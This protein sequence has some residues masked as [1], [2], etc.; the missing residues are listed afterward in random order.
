MCALIGSL[1]EIV[2][3]VHGHEKDKVYKM[4]P[5]TTQNKDRNYAL[6]TVCRT[7]KNYVWDN[8]TKERHKFLFVLLR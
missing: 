7:S 5:T 8:S 1:C 3:L 2:I 4:F 6:T